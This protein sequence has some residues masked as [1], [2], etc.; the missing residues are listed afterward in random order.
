ME[1][2]KIVTSPHKK[3]N[4]RSIAKIIISVICILIMIIGVVII[5]THTDQ[6]GVVIGDIAVILLGP[7]FPILIY[8]LVFGH[9][10]EI[11]DA[12]KEK[13]KDK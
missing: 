11:A 2:N 7:L 9:A 5:D 8:T 4:C 13:K 10:D 6:V 12:I 3:S 1:N